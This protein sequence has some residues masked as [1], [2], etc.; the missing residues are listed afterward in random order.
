[1]E[2]FEVILQTIY[3]LAD[4]EVKKKLKTTNKVNVEI[5]ENE[6]DDKIQDKSEIK[7]KIED[8]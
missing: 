1:M 5:E 7:S 4:E 8:Q 6:A 2:F 3:V